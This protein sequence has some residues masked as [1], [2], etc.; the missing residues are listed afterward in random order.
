MSKGSE[1]NPK[2]KENRRGGGKKYAGGTPQKYLSGAKAGYSKN[3]N[4]VQR[5]GERK[6][7]QQVNA[8]RVILF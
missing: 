8:H 5:E 7:Q 4:S 2:K 3:K 6:W 1:G